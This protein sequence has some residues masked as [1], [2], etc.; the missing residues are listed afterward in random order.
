MPDTIS[1]YRQIRLL[2]QVAPEGTHRSYWS[3][4]AVGVKRGIPSS[5]ILLDGFVGGLA[6]NCTTEEILEAVHAA[7]TSAMLHP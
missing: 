2:I 1:T 4:H 3:L 7:A 6:H 5:T